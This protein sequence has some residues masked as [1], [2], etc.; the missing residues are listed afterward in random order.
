M[1]DGRSCKSEC[2][3]CKYTR[4]KKYTQ[5][6][7]KCFNTVLH[8]PLDCFCTACLLNEQFFKKLMKNTNKPPT[9]TLG[10]TFN[11]LST[12]VHKW[13][14]VKNAVLVWAGT[15]QAPVVQRLNNLIHW[16]NQYPVDKMTVLQPIHFIHWVVI[17]PVDKV[18]QPLNNWGLSACLGDISTFR[19]CL[20]TLS[21]PRVPKIKIQDESKISF[22]KNT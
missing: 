8:C 18:I 9:D 3:Y 17:Y 10:N 20:L 16:L 14:N 5:H 13:T 6:C 4:S 19:K 11:L 15:H 21:L 2:W 1:S 22:C 7:G 12:K